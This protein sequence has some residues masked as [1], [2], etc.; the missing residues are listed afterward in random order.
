MALTAIFGRHFE[1]ENQDR[2]KIWWIP[3]YYICKARISGK[4]H[5]IGLSNTSDSREISVKCG[6]G[7]HFWATILDLNVK[8]VSD[9][10]KNLSIRSGMP[11]LV[12]KLL[13]LGFFGTFGSRDINFSGFS[14]WR[15]PP[16]WIM[17]VKIIPKYNEYYSI[18]SVITKLV[19]NDTSYA[20]LANL[21]QEISLFLV[22][23]MA[24]AAILKNRLLE[25]FP[26]T[27][28]RDMGAYFSSN[29][30]ILSNQSINYCRKKMVTDP[31]KMTLLL[32]LRWNSRRNS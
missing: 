3:F 19:G 1:F 21:A 26:T 13:H 32:R 29:R 6:V 18:I 11:N 25:Y 20:S 24:L 9:R 30:F 31:R 8:L 12:G 27:F 15:R 23:N 10:S 17:K 2:P 28:G 22:F 14:I 4:W 5:F 16:S 7:G